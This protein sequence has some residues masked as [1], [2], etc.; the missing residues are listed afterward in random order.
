MLDLQKT[1]NSCIPAEKDV[2]MIKSDQN[3]KKFLRTVVV[4]TEQGYRQNEMETLCREMAI[5]SKP[6]L[7]LLN[8]VIKELLKGG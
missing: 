8:D 7:E 5:V 1:E 4:C 6:Y 2:K 3:F